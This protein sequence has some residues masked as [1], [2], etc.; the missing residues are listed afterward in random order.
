VTYG[1][2]IYWHEKGNS[3]DGATLSWFIETADI[4][5]DE[6]MTVL[7]KTAWP[8]LADQQ[9]P[10]SLTLTTRLYPQGDE[11]TFG[12][13]MLAPGQDKVDFKATGR[14]YRLRISGNAAPSYARIGRFTFDVKLRG[15]K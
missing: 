4:Y 2:A 14:L 15:R 3:A 6:E 1:G 5:L 12:P 7:A 9:G 8:D 11:S 13:Y 10:V